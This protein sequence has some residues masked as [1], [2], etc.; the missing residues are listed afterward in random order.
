MVDVLILEFN[1]IKS[2][3][4]SLMLI[5]YICPVIVENYKFTKSVAIYT[6][7]RKNYF[8]IYTLKDCC[9]FGS[10]WNSD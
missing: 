1:K 3:N 8:Q 4:F 5:N 6:Q 7:T 9:N 2:R 10:I